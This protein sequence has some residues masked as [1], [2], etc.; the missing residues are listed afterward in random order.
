[1]LMDHAIHKGKCQSRPKNI[2][3]WDGLSATADLAVQREV[4]EGK[5]SPSALSCLPQRCA[6]KTADALFLEIPKK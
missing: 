1:M 5:A 6:I 3:H 4:P 2:R